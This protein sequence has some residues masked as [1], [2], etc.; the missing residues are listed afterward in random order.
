MKTSQMNKFAKVALDNH[1]KMNCRGGNNKKNAKQTSKAEQ[2][3]TRT[4]AT[5]TEYIIL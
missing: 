2:T 1:Q 3:Q 5:A 4:K